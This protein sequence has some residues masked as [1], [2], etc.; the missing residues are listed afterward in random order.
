MMRHAM[1]L[2][3]LALIGC[4]G[5]PEG[6]GSDDDL[7]VNLDPAADEDGDGWTN[8]EEADGGSDPYDETDRPYIGGYGK[9]ACRD[10]I[11]PTGNDIGDIAEGF[12]LV[13]QYGDTVHLADFCNRVVLIEFSG[14]T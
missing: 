7:A 2:W 10:D 5:V 9:D 8:G 6:A 11:Q 1:P 3:S 14:F 13:D 4:M 12:A